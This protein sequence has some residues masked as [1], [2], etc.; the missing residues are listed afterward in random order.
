[1]AAVAL[2]AAWALLAGWWTP[3]GPLTTAQA[4]TTMAV[5]LLAG[6]AVGFTMRSRWSFLVTPVV[7]AVVFELVRMGSVGPTVDVPHLS[8][9]GVIAFAVR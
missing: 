5:S 3:R 9:Y 7:F 8:T 2:A 1:M 6:A 4:L